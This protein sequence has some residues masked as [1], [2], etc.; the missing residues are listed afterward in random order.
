[1][2]AFEIQVKNLNKLDALSQRLVLPLV[3]IAKQQLISLRARVLEGFD[4]TGKAWTPL[5]RQLRGSGRGALRGSGKRS[6]W[7]VAPS[8]PQPAG[9]LFEVPLTAKKNQ[10]FKVYRSYEE[11][12]R[13]S[14]NNDRRDWYKT[15]QFWASTGVRARNAR[16]VAIS[17]YGSRKT[18]K[19]RVK[20]RD[21]GRYAGKHEKFGVF[22]YSD[23]ERAQAVASVK[24]SIDEQMAMR[25][26]QVA[27]LGRVS[28]RLKTANRRTSKL[29]GG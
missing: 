29:L 7:W 2:L 25:A 5:G 13:L 8:E 11:Y 6:K 16:T 21:I 15:G 28:A 1:M 27:E 26:G 10:G 14:P 9:W 23:A 19:Q 4:P 17:A 18:G 22:T 3:D 20:N 24:A 12:L